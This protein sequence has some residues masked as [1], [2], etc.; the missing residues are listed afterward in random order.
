MAIKTKRLWFE[1]KMKNNVKECGT[2]TFI[3]EEKKTE[4]K[5]LTNDIPFKY[6]GITSLSNKIQNNELQSLIKKQHTE[7]GYFNPPQ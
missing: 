7:L 3:T 6:L 2:E 5:V 1:S 4:I